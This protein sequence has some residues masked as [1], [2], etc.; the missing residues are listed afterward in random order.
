LNYSSIF[1]AANGI[2]RNE[3]I[4]FPVSGTGDYLEPVCADVAVVDVVVV[5]AVVVDVVVVVGV[6]VVVLSVAVTTCCWT[7]TCLPSFGL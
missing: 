1:L 7:G 5:D 3:S 6:V 2:F 4:Q